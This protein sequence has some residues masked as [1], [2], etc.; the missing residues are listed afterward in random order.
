MKPAG[1]KASGGGQSSS[2]LL[3]LAL[4]LPVIAA[5]LAAFGF[6]GRDVVL[7]IDLGTTYSAVAY[8]DGKTVDVLRNGD[9]YQ[10]TPSVVAI[11]GAS[12]VVGALAVLHAAIHPHEAIIDGKRVIGRLIDD[13]VTIAEIDRHGHRLIEH[14]NV[15]RSRVTGKVV[16]ARQLPCKDCRH[17]LAFALPLARQ[18]DSEAGTLASHRCLD[19]NSLHFVTGKSPAPLQQL[20][21]QYGTKRFLLVTPQAVGC[22]VLGYLVEAAK[23]ALPYVSIGKTMACVPADFGAIQRQ[24]T[25]ESFE[26]AGLKV[27]RTLHEP[28]AAA[29]AYG[30]HKED[31]SGGGE[32]KRINYVLVFDMGGG[33]LDVSILFMSHG[34]FTVISTAGD[35]KLGG[36]DFD[37][38]LGT[39]MMKDTPANAACAPEALSLEAERVKIALSRSSTTVD[40]ASNIASAASVEDA[41]ALWS[42][43]AEDGSTL[44]GTV[45]RSQFEG[46]CKSL[47]DRS[48]GPVDEALEMANVRIAEIDEI[49][50]VGGS[51]RLPGVRERL[52][53]YF[54][55]ELRTT[56]DPDLA[57]ALGAANSRA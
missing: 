35:N 14:P 46:H 27:I 54:N 20:S 31:A 34:S 42:C 47:F 29:I 12:F 44:T 39:L 3:T 37:D 36:E 5:A 52:R 15:L 22:I 17:D 6:T 33:T 9:G 45:T 11:D 57:V 53:T 4:A 30:L 25:L 32:K 40:G 55:R 26:R 49:V 41:A 21:H 13:A 19:S 18:S 51:S 28:T 23:A 38:C 50:M 48:L 43:R 8:S 2:S 56:V 24:A 16:S 1:P 10:S 7:G